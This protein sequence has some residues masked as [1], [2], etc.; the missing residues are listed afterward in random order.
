MK[1]FAFKDCYWIE[2]VFL[3]L[4]N[5]MILTK[6]RVKCTG[7]G[8]QI[9]TVTLYYGN[10]D[11]SRHYVMIANGNVMQICYWSWFLW[12]MS[13][14]LKCAIYPQFFTPPRF[15]RL[16]S[17]SGSCYRDRLLSQC[18][19]FKSSSSS[20]FQLGSP[21]LLYPPFPC[22]SRWH[23]SAGKPELFLHLL[24]FILLLLRPNPDAKLRQSL[25]LASVLSCWCTFTVK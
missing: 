17:C 5:N 23:I 1:C 10:P 3:N 6:T 15:P 14:L 24:L 4:F 2:D 11:P 21:F 7:G 9:R 16:S 19:V 8:I 20:S 25:G 12:Y 13:V 22:L 18:F